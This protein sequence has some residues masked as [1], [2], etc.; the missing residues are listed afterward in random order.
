MKKFGILFVCTDNLCRSPTA[1]GVMQQK[2]VR[3]GL[4]PRVMADSAGTYDFNVGEPVDIRVQK[5]AMRRDYDLSSLRARLLHIGDFAHFDWILAMDESVMLTLKMRC[6][7][8]YQCKLQYFT[9]ACGLADQLDVPDPFYG[10]TADFE[11]VLDLVE[12]GCTALLRQLPA[13]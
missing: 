12:A 5:H 10:K 9:H 2:L 11:R 4:D 8:K 1:Q 7:D 13:L 3:L 6:P